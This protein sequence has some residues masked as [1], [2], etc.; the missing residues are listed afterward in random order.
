MPRRQQSRVDAT[1]DVAASTALSEAQKERVIVASRAGAP[2]RWLRTSAVSFA[3][4]NS[5]SSD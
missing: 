5:L 2:T 3:T 4:A 1:F